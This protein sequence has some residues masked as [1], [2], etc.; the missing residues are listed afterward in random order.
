MDVIVN[1]W[2]DGMKVK[3]LSLFVPFYDLRMLPLPCPHLRRVRQTIVLWETV[4]RTTILLT[5]ILV[6]FY[7]RH[8]CW[9]LLLFS[10]V[11]ELFALYLQYILRDILQFDYSLQGALDRIKKEK[12]TCDLILG[13]GDAKVGL[14]FRSF[15]SIRFWVHFCMNISILNYIVIINN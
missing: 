5:P 14:C 4:F 10:T 6:P 15:I 8:P 12:R 9:L 2:R 1:C 3:C 7:R 11:H 13:V